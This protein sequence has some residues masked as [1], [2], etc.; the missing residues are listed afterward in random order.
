M[1][2][3]TRIKNVEMKHSKI[4]LFQAPFQINRRSINSRKAPIKVIEIEIRL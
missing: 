1:S 3:N 4:L 2:I